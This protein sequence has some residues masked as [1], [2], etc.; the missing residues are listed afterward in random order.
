MI[1]HLFQF[2]LQRCQTATFKTNHGNE[3]L[4]P[5]HRSCVKTVH[6]RGKSGTIVT[7]KKIAFRTFYGT[8]QQFW[9]RKQKFRQQN[10]SGRPFFLIWL[11]FLFCF[12]AFFFSILFSFLFFF[13]FFWQRLKVLS[14]RLRHPTKT[15]VTAQLSQLHS[16]WNSIE[17]NKR[18]SYHCEV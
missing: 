13:F 17:S 9:A 10:V 15:R 2:L 1:G 11:S 6:L 18:S 16:S 8:G 12:V 14:E 4:K 5:T 7:N 3:S